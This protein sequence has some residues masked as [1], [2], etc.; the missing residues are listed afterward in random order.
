MNRTTYQIQKTKKKTIQITGYPKKKQ[1]NA[2]EDLY[3]ETQYSCY[4][5]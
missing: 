3:H 1:S 4:V 2:K 5:R